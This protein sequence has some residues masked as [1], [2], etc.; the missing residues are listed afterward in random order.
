MHTV[1]WLIV[2]VVAIGP[3]CGD[4]DLKSVAPDS[5]V[6]VD[7]G[8][9]WDVPWEEGCNPLA[10][11]DDCL[12]PYPSLYFTEPDASTATGLRLNYSSEQFR[13]PDGELDFDLGMINIADGISPVTPILVNF[14]VDIDEAFLSGSGEQAE[15]VE[16][17]APIALIHSS[18]GT[19]IPVLTEMDQ[20]NRHLSAYDD[21]HPLIIRP[22]APMEP[23]ERY[24]VLLSSSLRDVDGR[25]LSSPPV[26]EALRD[27]IATD[28][29]VVEGMRERFESN[30]AVASDAGW[31]RGDL[32]LSWDFQVA[33]DT[34]LLGPARSMREQVMAITA[35]ASPSYT[36]DEVQTDPNDSVAWL[37]SGTFTPPSFLDGENNLVLEGTE[38]VHQADDDRTYP[39]TM[40]VPAVA[41]DHGDLSLVLVGHGLFG[42]GSSMLVGGSAEASFHPIANELGAVLIATDWVGLSGGDLSLIISEILTDLSRI[43]VVTDRL[44]QSHAN[45]LALVELALGDLSADPIFST[46]HGERLIN[47]ASV[48]YYG[49]S[50]GG[51]Q[52]AGQVA[53][54]PRISRAVLAVPGAG[55]SHLI[56]RSTQFDPLEMV[57]D[58]LYPDPLTQ[59]VLLAGVQT[60]FDWSDPANLGR[61]YADPIAADD[62]EK[63][64]VL[65]EAIGDCQVANITT[66][67]LARTIGASHLETATDPVFDL[68][69][70]P[71]PATGIVLTQIRVPEALDAYFPPDENTTPVTDNGVHNS[72]VLRGNIFEQIQVL[73]ST[74]EVI[75]PCDG[76]CDPE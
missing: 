28:D 24:I 76:P 67:L 11:R 35:E 22:L 63:V 1:S 54:S 66:D 47:P 57:I 6:G 34:H 65:Q 49:I 3:G 21:R 69:T 59:S 23:G 37:V 60:F 7:T 74:G 31:N 41:R 56:Q 70:V 20:A 40:V 18:T 30:F 12:L 10:I 9:V 39:F 36:I 19:A 42:T 62:P 43:R 26:F 61:L 50:L 14:G 38:V 51:I 2:M 13:G 27:G 46:E 48:M 32:L 15:T 8:E 52:G 4:D 5:P 25:A 44:V 55:W 16:S 29:S 71:A 33:S 72:A 45:N 68:D 17:G 73:F 64:V 75:H 58:A 53:L